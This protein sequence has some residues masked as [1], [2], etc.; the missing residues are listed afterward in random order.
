ME[1]NKKKRRRRKPAAKRRRANP[2][3][4]APEPNRRRRRKVGGSRRRRKNPGRIA[5]RARS[6]G[7]GLLGIGTLGSDMRAAWPALLGKLWVS[8]AV[9]R[10]AGQ[11][12]T[13]GLFTPKSSP[14]MG[15]SWTMGQYVIGYLALSLGSRFFGRFVPQAEFRRG[16]ISL[17]FDKLVWT[18]GL[19]RSTWAQ[20]QFG[21]D[22][23]GAAEGDVQRTEDGQVWLQQGGQWVAMQG[24]LV[25][26]SPLDG[27]LVEA[28]QLDGAGSYG[29]GHAMDP[30]TETALAIRSNYSRTGS[31]NKYA[32]PYLA[33]AL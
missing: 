15:E 18:E 9:R 4:Y 28:S 30:N 10:W 22:T 23:Y 11:F 7:G 8:W 13:G 12:G 5:T 33:G 2:E 29:Y 16:G 19:S 31:T 24:Q 3:T 21:G 6:F 25:S 17:L 1:T 14:T 32:A 20:Q 27:Q 26:A